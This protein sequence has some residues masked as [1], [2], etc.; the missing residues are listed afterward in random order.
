MNTAPKQ[1]TDAQDI[2]GAALSRPH[3]SAKNGAWIKPYLDKLR[4]SKQPVLV[5]PSN[6]TTGSMYVKA[7]A[8]FRFLAGIDKDYAELRNKVRISQTTAGLVLKF[9]D[10][11]SR[12][13]QLDEVNNWRNQLLEWLETAPEHDIWER[14]NLQVSKDDKVWLE[15]TLLSLGCEFEIP[16]NNVIRVVR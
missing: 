6:F 1:D 12:S 7:H 2:M 13:S 3:V 11:I 14:R 10:M 16:A 9:K 15:S 5:E 4:D 8:G